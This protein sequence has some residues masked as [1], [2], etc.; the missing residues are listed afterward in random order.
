SSRQNTVFNEI[1]AGLNWW[2]TQGGLTANLTFYYDQQFN[3]PT[4]YEPITMNGIG[5]QET[6]LGDIF[7]NMGYTNGD[8]FDRAYEY[9]NHL[10]DT[11]ETDWCYT[12]IVV[13]SLN[14]SDGKF[15]DGYF[16]WAYLGGPYSVMTYDN[17]GWGISRMS[18][19]TTHETGH[20]F[21][22][23]DEYCQP[24]YACCDF[25]YYGY[26][27]GYNGNC[28]TGN[29]SS[30]P[31]MMRSNEDAI[32]SYTIKQIGWLDSDGD[33]IPDPI[34]NVVSNT[35]DPH[36][37][38]AN[39]TSLTLTGSAFDIPYDSPTR[40]DV[41]INKITSV[42]FRL[43]GG[44]WQDASPADGSFDSDIEGY[45][46]TTNV[47]SNGIYHIETQ[48]YSSS[49]NAS[50]IS[51]QDVE[52][53]VQYTV[54]A[55]SGANGSIAPNGSI[56]VSP[57]DDLLFTATADTDYTVDLW[58]LDAGPIQ[59]GGTAFALQNIQSNHDVYVNF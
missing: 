21:L 6:W 37:S 48:A 1:V 3:I 27:F 14:D 4:Q 39:Q 23:A 51:S 42:Q 34:D 2:V 13:D 19:V 28:E 24:G 22:A 16:G 10:R 12:Y 46:F 26:L 53:Q 43:N 17:D 36:V 41:T 40:A 49:G 59:T 45:T 32:C 35:L 11:L 29:P 18:L 52:V 8:R 54:T 58:Y 38:P 7:Q 55:N 47:S 25:G 5:D 44:P 30:V 20:I 56:S 15:A 9:I 31:C 50:A 57:G 33:N